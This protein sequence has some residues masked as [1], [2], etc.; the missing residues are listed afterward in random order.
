MSNILVIVRIS[1]N[2]IEIT[3]PVY[4]YRDIEDGA[5]F[6]LILAMHQV[7]TVLATPLAT[8]LI[9][10]FSNYSILLI[11]SLITGFAPFFLMIDANYWTVSF[12]AITVAIGEAIYAPRTLDYTME[13]AAKGR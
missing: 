1:H 3:L 7:V 2:H 10:W 13:V 8:I 6:G 11:G 9:Y 12:Y 4:M 5:H